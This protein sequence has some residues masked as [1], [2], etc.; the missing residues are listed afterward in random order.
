MLW[1]PGRNV[2]SMWRHGTLCFE[3]PKLRIESEIWEM[4]IRSIRSARWVIPS[5]N[6]R[7]CLLPSQHVL[8]DCIWFLRIRSY[9]GQYETWIWLS[10]VL[11]PVNGFSASYFRIFFFRFDDQLCPRFNWALKQPWNNPGQN[12]ALHRYKEAQFSLTAKHSFLSSL[13]TVS[14]FA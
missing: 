13:E 12:K 7:V 6:S 14:H 10:S 9:A 8:S 4:A 5:L 1:G 11:W 3:L 2:E